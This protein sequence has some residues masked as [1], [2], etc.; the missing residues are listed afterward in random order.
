MKHSKFKN[1]G[2]GSHPKT[3]ALKIMKNLE[4][5]MF[6]GSKIIPF[7][8]FGQNFLIDGVVLKKIIAFCA[9]SQRDVVLEIGPGMGALTKEIAPR[10]KKIIAVEKDRRIVPLL[11]ENLSSLK[12]LK[13]IEEDILKIKAESLGLPKNYKIIANLPYNISLFV[14]RKFLEGKNPP[15]LMILMVQKEVAQKICSKKSSLPKLAIEFYAKPKI[16]FYVKKDAFWPKPKV[17][18]AVI[19]IKDI[20]NKARQCDENLFFS[21]IKAGFLFPRKTILNNLSFGLKLERETI[22]KMLSKMNI[23]KDIRPENIDLKEWIN[24]SLECKN[25]LLFN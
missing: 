17:D 6:F 3:K 18:G 12:N 11:K 1:V 24:L 22:E 21:V 16:L 23:R 7:K 2:Q 8:K 5:N 15:R 13:I 9:L 25:L 19:E 14:I 10:A 20:E 4:K